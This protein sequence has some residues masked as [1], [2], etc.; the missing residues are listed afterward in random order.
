L[1]GKLTVS[2]DSSAFAKTYSIKW[3]IEDLASTSS[4]NFVEEIF[5][6]TIVSLCVSNELTQTGSGLAGQTYF[7]GDASLQLFPQY[8]ISTTVNQ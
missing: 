8:A 4:S 6:L 3:K 5:D 2:T 1:S 7:V